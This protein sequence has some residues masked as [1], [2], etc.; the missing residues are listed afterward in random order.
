MNA[1]DVGII[2]F[3]AIAFASGF[4]QGFVLTVGQYVGLVAGLVGG[5]VLA[6]H[7]VAQIDSSATVERAVVVIATIVAGA[8]LGNRL[9]TM[10]A[11]PFSRAMRRLS[12]TAA[13]D[14][15]AGA[16]VSLSIALIVAW[17]AAETLANGPGR[18]ARL[19]QQSVVVREL[20]ALAPSAPDFLTNLQ[21][22]IT[23]ELGPNVF[24]GIEPRL[25]SPGTIDPAV[26]SDPEIV[27]AAHSVVKIEGRGCGGRVTGSGFPIASN[28]VITNAHVVA[29]TAQT[30]VTSE[31][32]RVSGKVILFDPVRDV[33]IVQVSG[34]NVPSLTLTD[35]TRGAAAAVIGY[36][37]GGPQRVAAAVV[38]GR[39]TARG[40][41]IFGQSTVTRDVVV[42][43]GEIQPGNSGGPIVDEAGQVVGVVFARS[44]SHPGQGFALT[45]KEIAPDLQSLDAGQPIFDEGRF[46]CAAD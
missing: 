26:A 43:S 3:A 23:D 24:I 27:A 8:A 6:P 17:A 31:R 28:L 2:L 33:A 34:L 35:I 42:V 44:L 5:A 22:L 16:F 1:V 37:G 11:A 19:V 32:G 39:M 38:D 18:P 13:A 4:R 15:A 29:G 12:V 7:L 25:P 46:Q 21:Q 10:A 45:A 14:N 40:Q 36:P 41:D 9:G 20:D 30:T